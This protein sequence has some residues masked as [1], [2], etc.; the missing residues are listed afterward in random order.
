TLCAGR[1]AL[2][3]ISSEKDNSTMELLSAHNFDTDANSQGKSQSKWQELVRW[4]LQDPTRRAFLAAGGYSANSCPTRSYVDLANE[5]PR[6]GAA[7]DAATA[8]TVDISFS[9]IPARYLLDVELLAEVG[10][11]AAAI[12]DP[13]LIALRAISRCI[14][15]NDVYAAQKLKAATVDGARFIDIVSGVVELRERDELALIIRVAN[16]ECAQME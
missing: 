8:A 10:V 14:W 3:A 16:Y 6:P 11:D 4:S 2:L 5:V 1:A 15:R 13:R 12:S 9:G 7:P